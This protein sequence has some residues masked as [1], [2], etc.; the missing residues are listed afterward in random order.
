MTAICYIGNNI[1]ERERVWHTRIINGEKVKKI[2]LNFWYY[3]GNK[4]K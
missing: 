1:V 3:G 2:V 4:G